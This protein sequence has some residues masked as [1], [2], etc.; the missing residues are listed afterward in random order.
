MQMTATEF[1]TEI[2]GE[3]PDGFYEIHAI[4]MMQQ[5][6]DHIKSGYKPMENQ[7][8]ELLSVSGFHNI[9]EVV[10]YFKHRDNMVVTAGGVIEGE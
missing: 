6:G 8:V 5:Y 7:V 10:A 3:E 2:N 9:M 1:W 4:N